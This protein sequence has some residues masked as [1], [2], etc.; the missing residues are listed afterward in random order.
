VL[1]CTEFNLEH[2]DQ[3]P[4]LSSSD[5]LACYSFVL[6]YYNAERVVGRWEKCE[7]CLQSSNFLTEINKISRITELL[8][9]ILNLSRVLT[10][11]TFL[12]FVEP[13]IG[14]LCLDLSAGLVNTA[15]IG[16]VTR[17]LQLQT[18]RT[19]R[20]IADLSVIKDEIVYRIVKL[21]YLLSIYYNSTV[22]P[23]LIELSINLN[24]IRYHRLKY[25]QF[26]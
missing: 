16:W 20:F 4:P 7:D 22:K 25:G 13:S 5:L 8:G 23:I 19:F 9:N 2:S 12:I 21:S 17:H 15:L 14:S 6:S 26:S 1:C 11:K 18:N 24:S 10:T 3:D